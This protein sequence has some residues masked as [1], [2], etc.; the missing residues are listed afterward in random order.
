M[1]APHTDRL[2]ERVRKLGEAGNRIALALDPVEIQALAI[3]NLYEVF[4]AR[5]A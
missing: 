1:D 3:Q 2:A 5:A 4:D